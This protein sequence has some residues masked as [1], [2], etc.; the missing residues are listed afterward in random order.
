[1]AFHVSIATGFFLWPR[2]GKMTPAEVKKYNTR[3]Y[4]ENSEKIKATV[5]KYRLDNL[6]KIKESR[7][8]RYWKNPEKYRGRSARWA[9]DNPE[10]RNAQAAKWAEDNPD[11]R[12]AICAK[13]VA[14]NPDKV[15]VSQIKWYSKNPEKV[16][17]RKHIRRAR[18]KNAEGS[19]TPTDIHSMLKQQREKCVVCRVDISETY[20]ID[21]IMPL[22]LGGSNNIS[23]IQLLCS[24][25]NLSKNAKHPIDFMQSRGFLL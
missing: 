17:A 16:K 1:M 19:F 21:H 10:K 18:E 8:K 20:Q 9:Q 3:Y 12:K 5:N 15:K 11:K 22:A 25:C 23:N 24:H 13:Y 14:E 6:E 7:R 2:G 4:M